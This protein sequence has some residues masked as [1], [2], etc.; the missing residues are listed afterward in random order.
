MNPVFG[1]AVYFVMW[2]IVLFAILPWGVRTAEEEGE[3]LVPGQAPSA[4]VAP[5][6][7]K[8][9]LWTTAITTILFAIYWL[10]YTQGWL[11]YD[12]LPWGVDL[13]RRTPPAS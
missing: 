2:W 12:D 3:A 5:N 1:A 10:V 6:L 13:N 11:T 9:A 4:P 7:K 8:K